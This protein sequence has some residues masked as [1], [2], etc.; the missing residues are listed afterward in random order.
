MTQHIL[1]K[2]AVP[3]VFRRLL[4][5]VFTGY[6]YYVFSMTDEI[7]SP[8]F[9]VVEKAKNRV[10]KGV[11][12]ANFPIVEQEDSPSFDAYRKRPKSM[13]YTGT[14]Y[15]F[16]NQKEIAEA[17]SC[18]SD[19]NYA[20]AG[21][22]TRDSHEMLIRKLG[23]ER[24]SF[25][26]RLTRAQ[27]GEFYRNQAVGI[28]VYDYMLNLG[29]KVGSYATNKLFEYMEA[30][31]PVI[32]TNYE[33]WEDIVRR[34][35]CGLCVAPGDAKAIS[36]AIKQLVGDPRAAYEMG[37]N[38]RRAVESEFNWESEKKTYC[39]LV[40]RLVAR[41]QGETALQTY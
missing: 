39:G 30:G 11:V 23:E 17:L 41:V 12:V 8:H 26:G 6:M 27:L 22:L 18:V 35:K 40:L 5:M 16:S 34:Y 31:L 10:A 14:V 37:L 32:C 1:E 3:F 36:L 15:P 19:V 24:F 25:H 21:Y 4:S 33:V 7:I 2:D 9:H 13:C 20:I 29:G 28:V 38:G